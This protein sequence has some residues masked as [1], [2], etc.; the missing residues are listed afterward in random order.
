MQGDVVHVDAA[1]CEEFFQ[2]AVGQPEPQIPAHRQ[3]DDLRREPE[4]SEG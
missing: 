1:F 4:P 2:V 3:H